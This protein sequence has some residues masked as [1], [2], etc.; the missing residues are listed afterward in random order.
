MKRDNFEHARET[1][2]L[3]KLRQ[4]ATDHMINMSVYIGDIISSYKS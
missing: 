1:A 4:N 2:T 3:Q